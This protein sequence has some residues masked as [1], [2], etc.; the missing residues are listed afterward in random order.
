[1]V[2]LYPNPGFWWA[3]RMYGRNPK[4]IDFFQGA[5]KVGDLVGQKAKVYCKVTSQEVDLTLKL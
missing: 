3:Y 5:Y 1:M 4:V 2:S